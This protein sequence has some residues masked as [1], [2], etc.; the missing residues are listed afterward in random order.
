MHRRALPPSG[1]VGTE[2]EHIQSQYYGLVRAEQG[3]VEEIHFV[4]NKDKKELRMSACYHFVLNTKN[5][6][7]IC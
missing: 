4:I 1:T 3:N 6:P 7:L 5:K 2:L